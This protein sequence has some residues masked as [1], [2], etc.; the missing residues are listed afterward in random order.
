MKILLLMQHDVYHGREYMDAMIKNKINFD[1]ISISNKK[2]SFINNVEDK[3]TNFLWKP[4]KFEKMI[5]K[6]KNY[7]EFKSLTDQKFIKKIQEKKYQ[8]GIQ[9]GGLGILKK[10]VIDKFSLGLLNFHPG[11]LPSYRGS[12]APEWQINDGKK[13]ISTCHLIDTGID[14]GDIIGKKKLNL[15]Y[16]DYYL[17][18]ANIYP[19]IANHLIEVIKEIIRNK[20]IK[21][22]EVQQNHLAVYRKYIG[23]Q[24]IEKLKLKMKLG[25]IF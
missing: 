21:I 8:V 18:R 1:V 11:D 25:N 24:Q 2:N 15:D 7:Y 19:E 22:S 13:I 12:S 9:G 16:S 4:E 6:V 23:D 20:T 14:T 17:M 3:R 5:D 10:E